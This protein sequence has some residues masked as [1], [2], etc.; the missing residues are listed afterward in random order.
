M[1]A[2]NGS[3]QALRLFED[4]ASVLGIDPSALVE[5]VIAQRQENERKTMT[6]R[7]AYLRVWQATTAA[8]AEERLRAMETAADG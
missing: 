6:V 5:R 3:S 1:R 7:A 4:E 2:R 8:D